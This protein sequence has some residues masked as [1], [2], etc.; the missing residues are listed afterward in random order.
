MAKGKRSS[1]KNASAIERANVDNGLN[2]KNRTRRRTTREFWTVD[3]ETDP[4]LKNRVPRPFIWGAYTRGEYREFA[5]A[6]DL[7]DFFYS[8][9][10]L[11]FAHNGGRFDWHYLLH[12]IEPYSE[13][14]VISGRM[15]KFKIGEAEYRDSYNLLPMPLRAGGRKLEIDYGILEEG[16]RDKPANREIIRERLRTDCV[17]LYDMLENFIR[18]YGLHLTFPS[19]SLHAWSKLSGIPKPETSSAFYLQFEPYYFGGRVECFESGIIER[20]LKLFDINSAYS[21]A[22]LSKHPWGEIPYESQSLPDS[23]AAIERS[24]I[25]LECESRGS[26]P[27]RDDRGSLLFPNDGQ[28]R[29]HHVTGWEFL[30][31]CET[32]CLNRYAIKSVLRLSASIDFIGYMDNFYK[33]KVNAKERGDAF[34]YECAK[35]FLCSLYGKFGSNPDNYFE[36]QLIPPRYIEA[37]F[38]EDGFMFCAEIGKLALVAR[39]VPEHKARFY[40]VA[41]A[42]SIT[43]YVRAYLWRAIRNCRRPV[44]VDTDCILCADLPNIDTD[45]TRLGAWKHEADIDYAAIAGKKLYA[46]RTVGTGTRV[47]K[48]ASKGVKL[49]AA[50]IVRIA[51]GEVILYE[52]EIPQYSFKQGIR[53]QNREIRKTA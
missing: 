9:N 30:A 11:V 53:F 23:R 3:S 48:T 1:P 47:W 14:L 17:Y 10:V 27:F 12:R 24:F 50:E 40:N 37:A 39:P 2:P 16:E 33:V 18:D 35:R 19:A 25:T 43:G 38:E 44:Y 28:S 21:F 8:R 51:Q 34:A 41:V 36:Y 29:I 4:F 13:V 7:V 6:D 49:S 42:A 52:P 45:S 22:M 15:A 46:L 20:P 31:A 26:L 5:N 32:G